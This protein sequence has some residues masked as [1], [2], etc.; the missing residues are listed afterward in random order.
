[1]EITTSQKKEHKHAVNFQGEN[2]WLRPIKGRPRPVKIAVYDIETMPDLQRVYLVGFYDG[3]HYRYFESLP[4]RP[5]ED[6]SAIDKFLQWLL[7]NEQYKKGRYRIYAHNG[8]SFDVLFIIR[9]AIE[10]QKYSL[11]ATP[12]QSS[13]LSLELK[14]KGEN[15][16]VYLFLDSLRLMD[17]SLDKLGKAFGFGGK[18]EGIDYETLHTD[19]R[20]YEYLE[21]DCRLLYDCLSYFYTAILK[22]GGEVG[23][24]APASALRS[25][26]RSYLAEPIPTSRHFMSCD[27][28]CG[29]SGC[30]HIFTREA[31]YGGRVERYRDKFIFKPV[32][33]FESN[34]HN[35]HINY[36]DINSEHN[37]HINYGDINSMYPYNMLGDMPYE[38]RY[39]VKGDIDFKRYCTHWLGFVRARIQIP[40]SCYLPPLPYRF[41]KKLC[42]P[43]GVFEGCWSSL[44]LAQIEK[45]GGKI[46]EIIQSVW[47]SAKPLFGSFVNHWYQYRDKKRAGY[48]ESMARVAKLMLNSLYGK[49]GQ[50]ED[51]QLIWIHPNEQDLDEHELVPMVGFFEDAYT[52]SIESPSPHIIPHIAAWITASARVQLWQTMMGYLA[53]G[54]KIW[55]CDTDSIVT[56]APIAESTK[57]GEMKLVGRIKRA[58]FIAPKLYILEMEDGT[59][60]VK[61][62]GFGLGFGGGKITEETL[63]ACLSGEHKIEAKKMMKLKE[64]IRAGNFPVMKSVFKGS[65]VIDNKRILLPD[66]NTKAIEIN[67]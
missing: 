34:E 29:T 45:V 15:K 27:G 4:M 14:E 16:N 65:K 9:W 60:D 57:M 39:E 58:E 5:E 8:G 41:N 3:E 11:Q 64:G 50:R 61:A 47:F 43:T 1:M 25:F 53:A 52:E 59:V 12:I 24:T 46:L 48:S 20:R 33:T 49:F 30:L 31:Y 51:R 6:G 67:G 55:Y 44:E 66:G 35:Y 63:K 36:G 22:D 54:H 42:F 17:A 28:D 62:K 23:V 38:L 56:S 2:T 40:E 37:S 26:R 19:S 21:R 18:I 32:N 10:R 13:V 7:A